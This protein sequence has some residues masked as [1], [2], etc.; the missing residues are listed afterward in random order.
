MSLPTYQTQRLILRP[1]AM[2]DIPAMLDM[3]QDPQV[4]H[5]LGGAVTDRRAHI[6]DLRERIARDWGDGLGYWTLVPHDAPRQ[7]L[8]WVLIIPLEGAGPDIE[9]GWRLNRAAWGHGYASEAAARILQHGFE[10]AGLEE[11]IAVLDP[12]NHRSANVARR[13][14]MTPDG[15]RFCYGKM[16]AQFRITR[17]D[18]VTR[19]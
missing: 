2:T 3:N 18:F 6:A 10:T 11:I 15:E 7:F 9:I 12:A 14:G 13:I 17:N 5:F 1:R 16:Q 19:S 8:G 4:M